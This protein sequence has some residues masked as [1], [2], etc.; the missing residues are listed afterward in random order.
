MIPVTIKFNL[1]SVATLYLLT[2]NMYVHFKILILVLWYVDVVILV[3]NASKV[4][5][6]LLQLASSTKVGSS[7]VHAK[8][9]LVT[10]ISQKSMNFKGC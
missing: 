4:Q 1:E 10:I 6:V 5:I 2:E 7:A 9:L 8:I 3:L